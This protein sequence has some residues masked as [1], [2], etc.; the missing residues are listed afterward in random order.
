[1]KEIVVE[2]EVVSGESNIAVE[3]KRHWE[4]LNLPYCDGEVEAE[5]VIQGDV[6][7]NEKL[8][9][10]GDHEYVKEMAGDHVYGKQSVR[11]EGEDRDI[12]KEEFSKE[13]VV[14]VLKGLKRGKAMGTDL[15]PNEFLIEAAGDR[16]IELVRKV[17]NGIREVESVPEVWKE[18]R[19]V[20]L[21]KG[22]EKRVLDNYRG[23]AINSNFGKILTRLIGRRLE[24]DVEVRNLLGWMQYGFRRK[25][26]STDA[27]F[28]VTSIIEKYKREK[29]RLS[30]A[31]LDVRKAYDKVWREG[32]WKVLR[33]L[34]YGGRVLAIIKDLYTGLTATVDLNGIV[35]ESISLGAGVR[36]GCVLSPL[37]F[38]LYVRDLEERLI[39]EGVG[40]EIG[41]AKNIPGMFFA[42]DIV[43]LAEGGKNLQRLLDIVGDFGEERKLVFN[44]KKCM[45]MINEVE[46]KD[47]VFV[48]S[49]N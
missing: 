25:W 18:S 3:I 27:I 37:L 23:I 31:F 20:L 16:F 22:G 29:R 36:Q 41:P 35:S 46:S 4:K 45:V 48:H 21:H 12:L 39:K 8:F 19:M 30:V 42:D 34:G 28:T 6:R 14:F 49:F 7:D 15:I 26:R 10:R 5:E 33:D 32:L 1:M 38:D 24:D 47:N 11:R 13:E 17:M 44:E 2:G 43:L 9:V 40:V